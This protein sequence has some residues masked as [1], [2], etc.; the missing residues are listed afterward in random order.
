M[1][2]YIITDNWVFIL[3]KLHIGIGSALGYLPILFS[4]K[5]VP[6]FAFFFEKITEPLEARYTNAYFLPTIL[7]YHH[8]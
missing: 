2:I 8:F 5:I 6:F 4:L 7:R 1:K 3:G